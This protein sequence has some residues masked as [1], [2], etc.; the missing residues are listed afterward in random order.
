MTVV[1]DRE[2]RAAIGQI[3]HANFFAGFLNDVV[4]AAQGICG[5]NRRRIAGTIL[6]GAGHAHVAFGFRN[7]GAISSNLPANLREAIE[8]GGFEVNITVAR[9]RA[10]PKVGFAAGA[11]A[12]LPI[13]S[14]PGALE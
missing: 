1:S 5:S 6:N 11:F 12:A 9:R 13:Q 7:H 4:K 3:G 2:L 14:V 8:A 10:A